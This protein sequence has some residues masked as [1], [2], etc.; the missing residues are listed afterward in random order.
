VIPDD[1]WILENFPVMPIVCLE[2]VTSAVINKY[3]PMVRCP[4]EVI[5]NKYGK[6]L[7]LLF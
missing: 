2:V 3:C 4:L 6:S 7:Y 1:K 5:I